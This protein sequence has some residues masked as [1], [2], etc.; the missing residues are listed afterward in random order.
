[1]KLFTC[2][3]HPGHWDIPVASVIVAE[4]EGQ[5]RELLDAAL[6]E[7]GLDPKAEPYTLQEIDLSVT[8]TIV[9]CDGDY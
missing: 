4:S 5:A 3:D 7:R 6:R 8:Q 1:M 9:L 2:T